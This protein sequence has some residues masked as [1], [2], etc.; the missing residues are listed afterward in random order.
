MKYSGMKSR[1]VASTRLPLFIFVIVTFLFGT[2]LLLTNQV[3]MIQTG[4]LV[5]RDVIIRRCSL[6]MVA[7]HHLCPVGKVELSH[8]DTA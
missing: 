4:A 8:R 7:R 6:E 1:W 5:V 2:C 3:S